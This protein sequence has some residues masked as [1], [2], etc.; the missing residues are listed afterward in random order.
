[1]ATQ[2]QREDEEEEEGRG[3]MEAGMHFDTSF[4]KEQVGNVTRGTGAE[5]VEDK[6]GKS[7]ETA[8]CSQ[9]PLA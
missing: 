2:K 8:V 1:M 5:L 6:S 9:P 4:C 7:K 3:D